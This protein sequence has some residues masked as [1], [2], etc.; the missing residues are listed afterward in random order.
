MN[1]SMPYEN[2]PFNS[3]WRMPAHIRETDD[4]AHRLWD[5]P[6]LTAGFFPVYLPDIGDATEV[7]LKDGSR[8]VLNMSVQTMLQRLADAR[9]INLRVLKKRLQNILQMGYFVPLPLA[10]D[11]VLMPLKTR[12][13]LVRGDSVHG[14]VNVCALEQMK[15]TEGPK[16]STPGLPLTCGRLFPCLTSQKTVNQRIQ[17]AHLSAVLVQQ[18]SI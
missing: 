1:P 10:A 13:A 11:I 6:S 3:I 5:S 16:G 14:F 9:M 12:N 15:I 7:W 4:P 2:M 8:L 17:R 18:F